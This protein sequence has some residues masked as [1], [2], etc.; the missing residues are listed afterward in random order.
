ML[1]N[2]K[3]YFQKIFAPQARFWLIFPWF[4]LMVAGGTIHKMLG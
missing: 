1:N 2:V 3:T 4:P